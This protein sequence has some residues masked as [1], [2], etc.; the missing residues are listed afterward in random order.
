MILILNCFRLSQIV[1]EGCSHFHL[2]F[3]SH[4]MYIPFLLHKIS[5]RWLV[6]PESQYDSQKVPRLQ[7]AATVCCKNLLIL[8]L[9]LLSGCSL[10]LACHLDFPFS[11]LFVLAPRNFLVSVRMSASLP[12][13][14][15]R[16][17]R[18]YFFIFILF[19]VFSHGTSK[20]P[21]NCI[22]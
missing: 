17:H 13:Y 1:F 15:L 22:L 2:T 6:R 7:L 12:G 21:N 8:H 3:V 5:P 14:F 19:N 16:S 4:Y 18:L 10:W 20:Y 11:S 9:T